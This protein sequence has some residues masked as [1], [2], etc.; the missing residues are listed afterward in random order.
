MDYGSLGAG[1]LLCTADHHGRL[2]DDPTED[3]S[4]DNGSGAGENDADVAGIHD[5][6]FHKFSGRT[7]AVLVHK[8]YA[9]HRTANRHGT[10][11][12]PG[13]IGTFGY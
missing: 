7:G 6:S 1:S 2:N 9:D 3:Y 10:V 5:D 12:L 11:L 8:Q 4:N 13:T